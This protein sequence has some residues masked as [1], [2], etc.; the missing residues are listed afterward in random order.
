MLFNWQ[1][2]WAGMNAYLKL[3]LDWS[4]MR[5]PRTFT[6]RPGVLFSL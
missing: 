1:D 3:G 2:V 4:W 6:T 5:W